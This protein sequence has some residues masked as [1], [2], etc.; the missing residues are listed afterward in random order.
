MSEAPSFIAPLTAK[1]MREKLD[2]HV[3]FRQEVVKV[4]LPDGSTMDVVAREPKRSEQAQ[5]YRAAGMKPSA[6]GVV[7]IEN[8]HA[9]NVWAVVLCAYT[10]GGE[11]LYKATDAEALMERPAS[12]P[13]IDLVGN[14]V[15]S[16]SKKAEAAGEASASTP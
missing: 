12:D 7:V 13:L 11:R 6:G 8:M 10:P 4:P 9:L 5:M 3:T 16:L 15:Q 1:Q 14:A 2:A